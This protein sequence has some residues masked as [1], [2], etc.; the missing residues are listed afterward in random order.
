MGA[1]ANG[2]STDTPAQEMGVDELGYLLVQVSK[3]HRVHAHSALE[4]LGV[5]RGQN[6][7]LTALAEEEGLAQSELADRL[8]VRPPTISNSL[9]R[10][11]AAG[12]I[13]RRPDPGDRR[14][15]RVYLT[16]AGR[17][18]QDTVVSLWHDLEAQT[19]A[20]LTPDQRD[21]LWQMLGQIRENL[22]QC[23]RPQRS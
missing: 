14:I 20:G 18:L 11:E 12:W 8:L 15:S 23:S 19:F 21:S 9:E 13:E 17:A 4:K 7:I 1:Y 2:A 16:E 5:Y 10:M 22:R 6:F 3:L